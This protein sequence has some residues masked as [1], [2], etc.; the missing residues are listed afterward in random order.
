MPTVFQDEHEDD[1]F[2]KPEPRAGVVLAVGPGSITKNGQNAAMPA[3][4]PGQKVVVA[5]TAGIR[6]PLKGKPVQDSTVFI[7]NAED[8]W[9]KC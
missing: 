9:A 3:L 1:L 2:V 8:I 7:F 4:V 5:P 6:V